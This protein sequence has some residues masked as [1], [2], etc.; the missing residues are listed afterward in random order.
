[1]RLHFSRKEKVTEAL[2]NLSSERLRIF[3]E[4]LA[5]AVFEMRLNSALADEIARRALL[6]IATNARPRRP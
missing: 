2:R 1:M 3:I 5:Q 4:Q 6:L